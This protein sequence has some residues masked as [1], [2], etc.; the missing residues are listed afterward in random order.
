MSSYPAHLLSCSTTAPIGCCYHLSARRLVRRP[1][2]SSSPAAAAPTGR[3]PGHFTSRSNL[4]L[5][6]VAVQPASQPEL[7]TMEKEAVEAIR[8]LVVHC[9]SLV[10]AVAVEVH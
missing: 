6:A 8:R 9:S 10:A 7:V 2:R 3:R 4:S 1:I 5:L